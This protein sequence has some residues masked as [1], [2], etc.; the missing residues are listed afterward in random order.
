[1]GTHVLCHTGGA[2]GTTITGLGLTLTWPRD[3]LLV[4]ADRTP[5]QSILAGYLRGTSAHDRGLTRVLQ[6]HRERRPLLDVLPEATLP[7]PEPPHRQR[8]ATDTAARPVRRRFLPGF[9]HLGTV[10]LF[11]AA[12]RDLGHALQDAPFDSI[13]DAGRIGVRGLPAGLLE[14]ATQV[15][16]ACRTSL[17]SLAAVRLYLGLLTEA[18]APD[19]LGLV[20]IGPGRPY[21]AAEV[22]EQFG[23]PVVCEIAWEP[24][25]AAELADGQPL[26]PRWRRQPLGRSYAE[27]ATRLTAAQDAER[28]RIGAPS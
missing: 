16:V 23:V 9:A 5:S 17:V 1:M 8:R 10:D 6:A 18:V 27:A 15:L 12:W 4:D 25:A 19:R 28:L 21:R 3:V 14:T 26:S 7:L 24:F 22:A 20:L 2:P 13:V 11:E